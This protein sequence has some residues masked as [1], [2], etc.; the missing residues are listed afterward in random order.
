VK[1]ALVYSTAK[2][3]Y[4]TGQ[5]AAAWAKQKRDERR[6]KIDQAKV[7]SDHAKANPIGFS[8]TGGRTVA[9]RV[10]LGCDPLSETI[11][12]RRDGRA[13]LVRQAV[14]IVIFKPTEYQSAK[15]RS[16][17]GEILIFTD[18]L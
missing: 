13:V 12:V 17:V 6:L 9:Y 5:S 4:D 18:Q 15:I 2:S 3:V 1:V 8:S 10:R 11:V 14:P 16:G 7:A